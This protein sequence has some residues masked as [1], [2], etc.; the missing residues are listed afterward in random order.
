MKKSNQASRTQLDIAL[1]FLQ[2]S[3]LSFGGGLSAHAFNILIEQKGWLSR[4]EFLSLLA[5]SRLFPGANM[6]NLAVCVGNRCGGLSG[7]FAAV[8]GLL[9]VPLLLIIGLGLLYF[10]YQYLPGVTAILSGMAAVAV[11]LTLSMGLKT[12]EDYWGGW[13]PLL[14]IALCFWMTAILRW[15]MLWVILLLLPAALCWGY[16]TS[17]RSGEGND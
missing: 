1:A 12:L 2:I 13:W 17:G 3:M 4:E 8:A 10:H 15:P 5:L 11:G 16:L 7:A 14:L 6:V 9:L